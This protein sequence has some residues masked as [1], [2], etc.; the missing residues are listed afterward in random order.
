MES[1][2][3][4]DLA[5]PHL[6][7]FGSVPRYARLKVSWTQYLPRQRRNDDAKL[8]HRSS[9]SLPRFLKHLEEVMHRHGACL[10]KG[11]CEIDCSF[12]LVLVLDLDIRVMKHREL[13]TKL[14]YVILPNGVD[15]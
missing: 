14:F 6:G 3:G 15:L 1:A 9:L 10:A 5:Y 7:S 8:G 2:Y 11:C 13:H 12:V 4:I